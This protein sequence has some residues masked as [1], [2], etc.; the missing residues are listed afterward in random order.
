MVDSRFTIAAA[1]LI[2][3]STAVL[4]APSFAQASREGP[5]FSVSGPG[6]GQ[7]AVRRPDVA[8]D[9]VNNVFLVVSGPRTHGRFVN[10]N[11]VPL[12]A[13]FDL[14]TS[15][16]HNQTPRVAYGN[17]MFLVTW[18]D[19]RSDPRQGAGWVYGRLVSFGANG[20]PAF[21]GADFLIGAAL[22]FV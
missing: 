22:P 13:D 20:A 11:G 16:S 21:V 7:G 9:P 18:L 17:G 12:G 4:P 8:Y 14:S 5:T 10:A 19:V 1:A 15:P 6:V 3:I 2:C